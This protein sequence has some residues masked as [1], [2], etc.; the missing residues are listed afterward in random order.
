M[1]GNGFT[2]TENAMLR[3]LRDGMPHSR[4]ELHACLPDPLNELNR[5]QIH[6]S[7]IRRKLRPIRENIVC[8]LCEG[9][10]HYRHIRLLSH[11]E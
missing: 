3:V 8:E 7:N 1:V 10:P 6:I 2:P 11:D 4:E 5:I 9:K